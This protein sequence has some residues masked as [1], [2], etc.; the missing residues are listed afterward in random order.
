MHKVI[1]H[2][3]SKL[4]EI[5]FT[6][7]EV[8]FYRTKPLSDPVLQSLIHDRKDIV[9]E[10]LKAGG[11]RTQAKSSALVDY[12]LNNLWSKE[13]GV[14][15]RQIFANAQERISKFDT[16]WRPELKA[17]PLEFKLQRLLKATL[18]GF[19]IK[20]ATREFTLGRIAPKDRMTVFSEPKY[21]TYKL[22]QAGPQAM[23]RHDKLKRTPQVLTAVKAMI[24]A[25]EA[26]AGQ[27]FTPLQVK[28]VESG[29]LQRWAMGQAFDP[30]DPWSVLREVSP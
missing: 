27:T 13:K 6:P 24:R 25:M 19:T 11:T 23:L 3:E 20:D 16:R 17:E 18:A 10:T 5:G 8:R 29:L 2:R 26:L 28:A 1:E 22:F 30:N 4:K 15:A 21:G 7:A 12:K 9:R 14:N